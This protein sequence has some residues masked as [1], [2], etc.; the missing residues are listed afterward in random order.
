MT[1]ETWVPW[2]F[3]KA[4]GLSFLNEWLSAERRNEKP[5]VFVLRLILMVLQRTPMTTTAL[6][7]SGPNPNLTLT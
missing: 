4:G 5:E 2:Q 6:K 7:D 3:V 1:I